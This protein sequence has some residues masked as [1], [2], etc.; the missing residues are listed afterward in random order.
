MG[1][2]AEARQESDR[3][4]HMLSGLLEAGV[5]PDAA[6]ELLNGYYVLQEHTVFS[7]VDLL[8]L[9]LATGTGVLYKWGAAP[10]YRKSED[11]VEKI[12]TASPPPG[13]SVESHHTAEQF[14]LSLR[15]GET[16]V[17]LSD[18]ACSAETEG[19]ITG[20]QG[21]TVRDLAG[22][23]AAGAGSEGEDDLTAIVLRLRREVS[24]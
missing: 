22:Y 10:S 16:L 20:F 1:T 4:V 8:Q 2:G 15:G 17:L 18:G 12:G 11:G 7:T 3:A 21:G 24:A 6:M 14:K 19:R 9:S 13:Y 23:L 5:A